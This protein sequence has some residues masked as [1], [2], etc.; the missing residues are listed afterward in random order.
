[1]GLRCVR[2]MLSPTF[3]G[4][5]LSG[6]A[7]IGLSGCASMSAPLYGTYVGKDAYQRPVYRYCTN[8]GKCIES[9]SPQMSSFS[10]YYLTAQK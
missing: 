8:G 10:F 3:A 7:L 6:V 1:M 5:V 2:R 4:A 9:L